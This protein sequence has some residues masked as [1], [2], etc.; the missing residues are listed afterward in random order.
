MSDVAHDL[1]TRHMEVNLGP[2]H[3]AMHGTIRIKVE[4]DGEVIVKSTTEVG[5]LHRAFEKECESVHWAQCMPYTDRL[6][7]VSPLINNFGFAAAVEKLL[8]VEIPERAKYIRVL[9]AEISRIADHVTCLAAVAMELGG[10]TPFLYLMEAR[11]FLYDLIEEVCG[12]R[13]TVNY[14]RFGG[15]A[16]DL[17]DGFAAR[18]RAA[19]V[20]VFKLLDDTDKLLTRNR[21]FIDRT[22]GVGKITAEQ[23]VAYGITGPFL[24]ATGVDYDVRKAHPYDVYERMEFDIPV[25]DNGDS[26]DRW[27]VRLEEARQSRKIIH[28]ALAQIPPGPVLLEDPRFVLPPKEKVHT[29]IEGLMNHFKLVIDG[30]RV[31]PGEVY[32]FSEAGNGEL[33][34]YLV[35]DGGGKPYKCR[36]RSPCFVIMGA[37][38][39]VLLKGATIADVVPIFGSVNMIGGECDR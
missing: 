39:D 27:L 19:L 21:I 14:A 5:F 16:F 24:R 6:N 8:S 4:L 38:D 35:S 34:F 22:L 12:A 26:Y 30:A 7:Y 37:M 15:V 32:S 18:V 25:G 11:E 20:K 33:G 10:F 31:P 29:T 3:P 9:M 13:V 36:V 28:Q 2:S 1:P 17:P 23:A